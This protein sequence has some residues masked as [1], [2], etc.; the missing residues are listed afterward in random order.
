M[1]E[2]NI[3]DGIVTSKPI[4]TPEHIDSNG[5]LVHRCVKFIASI[6]ITNKKRTKVMLVAYTKL[7]DVLCKTLSPR[8]H[9]QCVATPINLSHEIRINKVSFTT[10]R[11]HIDKDDSKHV[12]IEIMKGNRPINWNIHGHA[13]HV[14]WMAILKMRGENRYTYGNRFFGFARVV[15]TK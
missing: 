5:V 3:T 6:N 2:Y 9:F 8:R 1:F 11:I 15:I 4:Y 13:D 10:N 12:N 14:L 7:A